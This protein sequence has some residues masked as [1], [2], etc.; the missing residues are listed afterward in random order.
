MKPPLAWVTRVSDPVARYR[1]G[2]E[3]EPVMGRELGGATLGS[4]GQGWIG[5]ALA[6]L[7]PA[8]GMRVF[9]LDPFVKARHPGLRAGV[10]GHAAGARQA[11]C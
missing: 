11:R 3:P 7:A 1:A 10:H 9:V 4:I 2:Q 8:S 6:D 5:R